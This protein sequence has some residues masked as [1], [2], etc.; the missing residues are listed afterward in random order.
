LLGTRL[1]GIGEFDN[2][3]ELLFLA[4][5]GRCFSEDIVAGDVF[6][7]RSES[8]FRFQFMPPFGGRGRPMLRPDQDSVMSY[9]LIVTRESPQVYVPTASKERAL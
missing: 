6:Y 3:Y 2:G 8:L 5:D 1:I 4:S 9:G 7:Y